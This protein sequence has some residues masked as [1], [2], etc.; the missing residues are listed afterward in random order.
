MAMTPFY[1]RFRDLAFQE[2]RVATVQG[3]SDM[4]DEAYVDHLKRHYQMFKAAL[5]QETA[6]RPVRRKRSRKSRK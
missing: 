4:P 1:T 5:R 2:M 3:R 6:A